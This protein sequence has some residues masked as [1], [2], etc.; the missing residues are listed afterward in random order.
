MGNT[1]Y[2][3]RN[4]FQIQHNR[5]LADMCCEGKVVGIKKNMGGETLMLHG[6]N[7]HLNLLPRLGRR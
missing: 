3:D 5:G 1:T 6:L 2:I 7:M 4:T